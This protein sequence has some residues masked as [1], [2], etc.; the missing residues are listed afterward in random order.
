MIATENGQEALDKLFSATIHLILS[1]IN[2]PVMD[3]ISFLREAKETATYL[4]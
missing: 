4:P 1:N 3:G 2:I